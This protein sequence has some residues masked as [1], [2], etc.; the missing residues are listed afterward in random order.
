M[1]IASI[2]TTH[3]SFQVLETTPRSQTAVMRL[4]PGECSSDD[5]N[6]HDGSDQTLLMVEGELN[7]EVGGENQVVRQGDSLIVRA[8]TPHRFA[9]RGD[10][11]AIASSV[12]APPAYPSGET[13]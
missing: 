8:N 1:K 2:Q 9:N 11:P 6:T 5:L 3:A 12:Y 10:R 4:A 7:A 13:S